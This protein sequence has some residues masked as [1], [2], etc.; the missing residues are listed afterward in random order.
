M[1]PLILEMGLFKALPLTEKDICRDSCPQNQR[2]FDN[3]QR[4]YA[5]H[6][7]THAFKDNQHE[8]F[9]FNRKTYFRSSLLKVC[10]A[11]KHGCAK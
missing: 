6:L 7:T 5:L 4:Y 1:L 10:P 9:N 8:H 11:V 2:A 3:N